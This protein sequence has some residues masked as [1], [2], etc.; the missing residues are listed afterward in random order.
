MW[1]SSNVHDIANAIFSHFFC[2]MY[3]LTTLEGLKMR[4][5]SVKYTN[6]GK[7]II[8]I[9]YIYPIPKTPLM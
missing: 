8:Y 6:G 9:L 3:I 5:Y 4:R 2:I 7:G 1:C